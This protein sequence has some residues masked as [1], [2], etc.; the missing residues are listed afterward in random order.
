MSIMVCNLELPMCWLEYRKASK[1]LR[2]II[3]F[4]RLPWHLN[5][6]W[7]QLLYYYYYYLIL[8][9]YIFFDRTSRI[10]DGFLGNERGGA[11][12]LQT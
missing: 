3:V 5:N 6:R 2:E 4:L 8:Y 12:A 7:D 1:S 10:V 11:V 9:M